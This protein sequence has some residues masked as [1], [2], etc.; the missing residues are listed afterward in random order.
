MKKL[1][2]AAIMAATSQALAQDLCSLS[3]FKT[4]RPVDGA[5]NHKNLCIEDYFSKLELGQISLTEDKA[6]TEVISRNSSL[7]VYDDYILLASRQA[8]PLGEQGRLSALEVIYNS[9]INNIRNDNGLCRLD[10]RVGDKVLGFSDLKVVARSEQG[11]TGTR[12]A[13]SKDEVPEAKWRLHCPDQNGEMKLTKSGSYFFIFVD[14][15]DPAPGMNV[16]GN[17]AKFLFSFRQSLDDI[18]TS[19][20]Q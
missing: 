16:P 7:M 6:G 17:F 2:I 9:Y 13:L 19:G 11:L 12:V 3:M 20:P 10:L 5:T 14:I 18:K 8:S 4:L 15:Y 1:V